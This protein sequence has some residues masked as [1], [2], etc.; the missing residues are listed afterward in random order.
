VTA[1]DDVILI[2]ENETVR[3]VARGFAGGMW[4]EQVT[5]LDV[6]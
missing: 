3:V 4:V 1:D 2:N 5:E 6:S